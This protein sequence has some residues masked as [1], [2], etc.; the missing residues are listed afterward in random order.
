MGVPERVAGEH[1]RVNVN[2]AVEL[3]LRA[4]LLDGLPV[5]VQVGEPDGVYVHV[6]VPGD[7]VR[8]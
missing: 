2:D 1:V 4:A 3:R 6:R 7:R 8:E 5:P